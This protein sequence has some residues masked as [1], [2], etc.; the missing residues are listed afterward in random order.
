MELTAVE[1]EVGPT[2][3]VHDNHLTRRLLWSQST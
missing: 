2:L 3:I 1:E